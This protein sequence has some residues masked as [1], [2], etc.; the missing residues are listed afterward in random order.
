MITAYP[1]SAER[2]PPREPGPGPDHRAIYLS[3]N[4][5]SA[6]APVVSLNAGT[7]EGRKCYLDQDIADPAGKALDNVRPIR[8]AM[9][10]HVSDLLDLSGQLRV[11][12]V[13]S[14]GSIGGSTS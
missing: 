2:M 6:G 12:S 14:I 5:I 7:A 13:G 4:V 8:G 3:A 1:P 9:D 10:A 11:G